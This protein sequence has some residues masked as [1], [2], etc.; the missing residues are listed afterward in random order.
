MIRQ[1]TSRT[2]KV[3]EKWYENLSL[4]YWNQLIADKNNL[5]FRHKVKAQ[6]SLQTIKETSPKKDKDIDK[7]ATV[8][9]LPPPI[10]AK[11]SK[12]V[13]EISKFF[14][15]NSDNKG[16]K[17]Y[18]QASSA[19]TNTVRETLKIKKVFPNLQN[20]KIENIQKIISSDGK[21]KPQLNMTTK[22]PSRKQVI[23]PI[24][25]KNANNFMKESSSH[26]TNIN[27][28]LKNIKLEV[29][30]NFIHMEN[31]RLVITTN[32]VA[33][34]LNLQTIEKYI[35]NTYNI[36]TNH[37]E[38]PRLSQ[39]KSFLKIICIP[40]ISESTNTYI[41]TE[42]VEKIIKENHIFNNIV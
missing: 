15:K 41:S 13:V 36:K 27:R 3:L 23:V 20:K 26:V 34:A 14:K 16:K 1:T 33:S 39:S 40:Y 8:S 10:P 17:S 37:V 28:A 18:T 19:N 4:S 42:N 12:K 35:K 11:S 30:A 25:S 31:S 22:G 32:K 29:M 9:V 7:L 38:S 24:N 5:S 21:T 6:F 2:L